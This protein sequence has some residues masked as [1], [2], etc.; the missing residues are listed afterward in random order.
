MEIHHGWKED[1]WKYIRFK[2]RSG[3]N[4]SFWSDLWVGESPLK[5]SFTN[6]YCLALDSEASME[7]CFDFSRKCQ[8]PRLRREPND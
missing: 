6:I 2:L 7:N 3:E 4:F 8:A 5:D 1:F